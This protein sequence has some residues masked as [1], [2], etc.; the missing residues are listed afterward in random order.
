MRRRS[1][2]EMIEAPP[3]EAAVPVDGLAAIDDDDDDDGLSDGAWFF[4]WTPGEATAAVPG[5]R[6][7]RPLPITGTA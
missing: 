2:P 4:S 6:I 5:N 1:V 3:P 7:C